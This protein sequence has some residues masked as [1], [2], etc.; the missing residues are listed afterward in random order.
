[1]TNKDILDYLRLK[2]ELQ[3]LI[4][5]YVQNG[6]PA[7][8]Q[9]AIFEQAIGALNDYSQR[10]T[11]KANEEEKKRANEE[12]EKNLFSAVDPKNEGPSFDGDAF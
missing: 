6:I 3:E 4:N 8:V 11:A 12:Y 9:L 5:K 1:M 7:T 10:E 2:E